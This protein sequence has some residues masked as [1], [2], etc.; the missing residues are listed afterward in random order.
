MLITLLKLILVLTLQK[1]Y[2]YAIIRKII[3]KISEGDNSEN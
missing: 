1:I 3:E 2:I